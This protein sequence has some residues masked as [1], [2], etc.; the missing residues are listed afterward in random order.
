M[1]TQLELKK[2]LHY[3]PDTGIFTWL[4]NKSGGATVGSVAG[5]I[6][7]KGYLQIKINYKVYQLHRLAWLY[8]TGKNPKQIIDHIN[9]ISA[10][11]RFCNL[12]EATRSQNN[13]NTQRYKNNNSG[14]KGVCFYAPTKKFAAYIAWNKQRKNIGYFNTAKEASEAYK[15]YAKI[16]HGEFYCDGTRL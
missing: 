2:V 14:Y 12:R 10:D 3:D 16:L 4:V 15:A 5:G 8:M 13:M 11:N 7:G 1:I 9:G 6:N